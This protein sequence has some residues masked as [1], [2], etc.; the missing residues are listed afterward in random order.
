MDLRAIAVA[1]PDWVAGAKSAE[2]LNSQD[3][4]SLFN[5]CRYAALRA[6]EGSGVW[7]DSNWACARP[8]LR[9]KLKLLYSLDDLPEFEDLLQRERPNLLMIGAMSLCLPG[10]IACA[11][12]ARAI[13]G[14]SALI[15]LGGRHVN[16]T[17]YVEKGGGRCAGNVVHHRGSPLRL[18]ASGRI[19]AVFDAVVS[20]DGEYLIAALGDALARA[21]SRALPVRSALRFIDPAAPGDWILGSLDGGRAV[22]GGRPIVLVSAG[23]DIDYGAMPS[24]SRM[25]GASAAFDVFDGRPTAHVYSDT[26]RGCV[27]DCAFCSERRSVAGAPRDLPNGAARLWRQLDEACDTLRQDRPGRGASAFVEDSVLLGGSP[28]LVSSFADRLER[29]PLDIVFGAQLTIDQILTRKAEIERLA[30]VGL[31]YVFVGI[32]TLFPEAVGGMSK[33]LGRNHLGRRRAPW[34]ARTA[35]AL[36]HLKENGIQ[37]G[38]ALLFGLGE[39][40]K[41]RLDLIAALQRLQHEIGMPS[42]ISANWAVQHPLC[43]DDDNANYDY[44]EWGTPRGPYLDCFHRFGEASLLY[45]L[46]RVGPPRLDEVREVTAALDAARIAYPVARGSTERRATEAYEVRG[47]SLW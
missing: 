27:Y 38:G 23:L 17:M 4:A 35:E 22:A 2:A 41:S 42:P 24:P 43:G 32:E 13:L 14:D 45:P 44:V 6:Q 8:E 19:P 10:A 31:N 9:R 12:R 16:E 18:M 5:A 25:F 46:P 20:G 28:R 39:T 47:E 29:Q 21:F 3:P 34:L 37:C 36:A 7:A 15:V 33:D 26:G 11:E 1:A 40:H 30:R